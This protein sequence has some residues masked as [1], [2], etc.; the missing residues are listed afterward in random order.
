[1]AELP[2]GA[3]LIDELPVDT[4]SGP[5]VVTVAPNRRQRDIPAS[6]EGFAPTNEPAPAASTWDSVKSTPGE[7]YSGVTPQ[8]MPGAPPETRSKAFT[9]GILPFSIDENGK[10][11]FDSDAGILGGLKRAFMTPG[12]VYSGKID[13]NTQEGFDRAMELSSFVTPLSPAVRASPLGVVAPKVK[14]PPAEALKAAADE[15]YGAV[16]KAGVDYATPA[17]TEMIGGFRTALEKEGIL[18][19]SAPKTEAILRKFANPPAGSVVSIKGLEA[20][21][22]AAQH[23]AKEGG[24]PTAATRLIEAIDSFIASADPRSVVAGSGTVAG[25]TITKARANAAAHQRSVAITG[26]EGRADLRAAT[27][28]PDPKLDLTIRQRAGGIIEDQKLAQRFTP[29]ELATLDRLAL[30]GRLRNGLRSVNTLLDGSGGLRSAI[31]GGGL[32]ILTGNPTAVA[33]G[34]G[35]GAAAPVIGS[36][37]RLGQNSLSRRALNAVDEAT[38]QRSPLYADIKAA[39][40]MEPASM[41]GSQAILGLGASTLLRPPATQRRESM[42]EQLLQLLREGGA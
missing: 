30:G 25:E 24:E 29:E 41:L 14:A 22:R 28:A 10:G 33:I 1:M 12:D 7:V 8:V 4:G 39:A 42:E 23:V 34:T 6:P 38:R 36:L 37:A 13:L 35:V 16:W 3:V 26:H 32:G 5:L 27:T 31:S 9:G 20:A 40:P 2:R 15:G 11:R 19:G 21:R 18:A 17:V